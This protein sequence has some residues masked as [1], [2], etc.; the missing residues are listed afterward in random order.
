MVSF[1]AAAT[2][3]VGVLDLQPYK[4]GR[5]VLA[6]E[7]NVSSGTVVPLF[8]LQRRALVNDRRRVVVD[9]LAKVVGRVV[10]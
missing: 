9:G 5:L 8:A 2:F 1:G 7:A 4:L 3:L 10:R 6:V